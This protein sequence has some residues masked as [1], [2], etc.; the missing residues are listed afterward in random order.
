MS[1]LCYN[2]VQQKETDGSG[3]SSVLI[4]STNHFGILVDNSHNLCMSLTLFVNP[5]KSL[6][7]KRQTAVKT[8][9]M[10]YQKQKV[11]TASMNQ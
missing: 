6:Q 7:V 4:G 11:T 5:S 10:L 9:N 3:D 2:R 8:M 1:N